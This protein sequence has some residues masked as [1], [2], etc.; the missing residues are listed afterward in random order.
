MKKLKD[1]II[2]RIILIVGWISIQLSRQKRTSLGKIVGN[3][4]R[5]LSPKREKI[6]LENIKRAFPEQSS[7][8]HNKI[9]KE[10][11][12]NLGITMVELLALK[13]F[14]DNDIR[15]YIKY[16]NIDMINELHSRGKGVIL[17]SG[18]FGNWELL[19]YSAGLFSGLPAL[20]IVKP[21][22]NQVADEL[23]NSYRTQRG[24]SVISMYNAAFTIFK[25]LKKGGVVALLADQS[26]TKDKDI[27]IDFFGIPAATYESPAEL[28]LKLNVPIVMGFAVRQNDG[29]YSV[30]LQEI[31]HDDLEHTKEGIEELTR[32]HV[33]AL[34]S[35]VRANPGHWA[36]QHRKWKHT[37]QFMERMNEL[38]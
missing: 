15:E 34:E 10:S 20:I 3:F 24:N 28:A 31:K 13:S 16:S 38:S 37:D 12:H 6:T 32:R 22:K 17:L 30:D 29:T 19:A 4:L 8:W 33:S 9:M 2:T 27:Y 7:S 36:W 23:L 18:H 14:D 1:N 21:Q 11:Y 26:A 25:Q 5:I 35:A